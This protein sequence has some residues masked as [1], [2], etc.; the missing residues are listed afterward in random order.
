M[1]HDALVADEKGVNTHRDRIHPPS[2]INMP[3]Q[4]TLDQA[5]A[6][7]RPEIDA[8]P[9]DL[10]VKVNV[11]IPHAAA[12]GMGAAEGLQ[13]L[14]PDL[15]RLPDY[16]ARPV[17]VIGTYAGAALHAHL[18]AMEPI[19]R[20][21]RLPAMLQEAARLRGDLRIVAEALGRFDL[22]SADHVAALR[23]GR[24]RVQLANGLCALA[25]IF[26]QKWSE[27]ESRVPITRAMVDRAASL[28]ADLHAALG[29]GRLISAVE[30]DGSDRRRTRVRA[31]TLFVRAY[32]HCRRGVAF[33]R[34]VHGDVDQYVPS[35]YPKRKHPSSRSAER[36]ES[37]AQSVPAPMGLLEVRLSA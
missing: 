26:D 12:T 3:A 6:S 10:L 34:C 23:I 9:D 1:Q 19:P 7:V 35:L 22:L 8:V 31:F 13:G 5:F 14:L 17:R 24:S 4:L 15:C 33:L 25:T 2:I 21:T 36:S 27:L 20:D 29:K 16:D 18:L 11:D 37:Q 28:G 32:E 30:R